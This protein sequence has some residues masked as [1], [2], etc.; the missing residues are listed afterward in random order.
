MIKRKYVGLIR[1]AA[2]DVIGHGDLEVRRNS[3]DLTGDLQA[4]STAR[5]RQ[6]RVHTRTPKATYVQPVPPRATYIQPVPPKVA[7]IQP[8][9][10]MVAYIQPVPPWATYIQPVPPWART[11]A[12]CVGALTV[13]A[14]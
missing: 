6:Q 5:G 9:P 13:L 12:W 2:Q 14:D 1:G 11:V 8:V 3:T 7:Y 4:P 10:P